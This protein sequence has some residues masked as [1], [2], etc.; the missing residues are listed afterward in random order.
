MGGTKYLS[1]LSLSVAFGLMIFIYLVPG[2]VNNDPGF[3]IAIPDP[4]DSL[5]G[6]DSSEL[7]YPLEDRDEDYYFDEDDNVFDLDDPSIIDQQIEYDPETDEYI[8]TESIGDFDY[9]QPVYYSYEEFFQQQADKS[10][11]D[12][13]VER[14]Q[15]LSLIGGQGLIPE[16]YVGNELFN[17]IFGG[18]KVDIRPKGNI[19]LS[20]GG[21]F[22]NIE[23]PILTEQQRRQGGFDFDMNI[24]MSVLGQIGEK[25]KLTTN[26]N[27][28]A[29]FD[30][31]NQVKLEY[32]GFEDEIIQKIEAGNVSLPLPTTLI[33]GTQTLFGLKTELK[34]G[35]LTVTN[36]LSQQ[37][38]STENIKIE[39]GAEQRDY[40][41]Y[42]DEYDENRHFFLSQYF[43]DNYESWLSTMPFINS[44]VNITR[45]EVWV[46]NTTGATQNTRDVVGFM[47]IGEGTSTF[48][49]TI[50]G[51]TINVLE[52][53]NI[54]SNYN[55]SLYGISIQIHLPVISIL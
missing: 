20:F 3:V 41:I 9:R 43:R 23:N 30:F 4:V 52:N 50:N 13:W 2:S 24:N 27:T 42:A 19:E 28:E 1:F 53:N 35:R 47:D 11:S 10:I 16:L 21:N 22:Q 38:S 51:G 5:D 18:N 54:P 15:G 8:I 49:S 45:L 25:L 26:Y 12:Y 14:S 7:V 44:P 48:F 36:I 6:T 40:L 55:N 31:E 29:T 32:T 39:G 46:T 34:F 33:P 37:K 17:R